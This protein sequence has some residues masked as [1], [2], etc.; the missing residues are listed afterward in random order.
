MFQVIFGPLMWAEMGSVLATQN[1]CFGRAGVLF[2]IHWVK[3]V[4][5][6]LF[7]LNFVPV[8]LFVHLKVIK[9]ICH[10]NFFFR[11]LPSNF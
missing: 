5:L 1:Y 2:V 9:K 4:N 6:V 7:L 3:N 10:S 11:W 8:N